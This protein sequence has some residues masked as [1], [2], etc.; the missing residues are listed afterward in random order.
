MSEKA[1]IALAMA[2][3]VI[4]GEIDLSIAA[5]MANLKAAPT[6]P[7]DLAQYRPLWDD[8]VP[9]SSTL[10]Y[11]VTTDSP[12]LPQIVTC[13]IPTMRRGVL[14]QSG[15]TPYAPELS[16]RDGTIRYSDAY[17]IRTDF[18]AQRTMIN[19]DRKARGYF[20]PWN[21]YAGPYDL[22]GYNLDAAALVAM[23]RSQCQETTSREAIPPQSSVKT[24]TMTARP[25][26]AEVS[27]TPGSGELPVG[28]AKYPTRVTMSLAGQDCEMRTVERYDGVV[29]K[30]VTDKVPCRQ[31]PSQLRPGDR[32]TGNV[33]VTPEGAGMTECA[34]RSSTRC[35]FYQRPDGPGQVVVYAYRAT[36]PEQKLVATVDDAVWS[37]DVKQITY[38]YNCS[39]PTNCPLANTSP[40]VL[41]PDGAAPAP[42]AL[43][44]VT[45]EFDLVGVVSGQ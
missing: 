5:T 16:W 17:P 9:C 33:T 24:M 28:G 36:A 45:R 39:T 8:G 40:V 18:L 27:L 32:L 14:F 30:D 43:G 19:E 34:S 1:L 37:Y 41:N 44:T 7:D 6:N 31:L 3:L 25:R 26:R 38:T 4:A 29:T 20:G 11:T 15:N 21:P 2:L 12:T 13:W 23:V 42:L 22:V 35:W 10:E